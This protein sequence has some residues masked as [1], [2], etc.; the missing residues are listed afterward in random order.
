[1]ANLKCPWS[2]RGSFD[3]CPWVKSSAPFLRAQEPGGRFAPKHAVEVFKN[4]CAQKGPFQTALNW[5][6]IWPLCRGAQGTG[7]ARLSRLVA[8]STRCTYYSW[9]EL[10]IHPEMC[11]GG[12]GKAHSTAAKA[13]KMG[14]LYESIGTSSARQQCQGPISWARAAKCE[15]VLFRWGRRM[16]YVRIYKIRA[17]SELKPP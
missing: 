1:M 17:K 9:C 10:K 13:T 7:V 14:R 6:L 2:C 12:L 4:R 11:P 5:P 16:Q 8:A 15:V 3:Y